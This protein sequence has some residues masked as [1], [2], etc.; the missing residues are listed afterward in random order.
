MKDLE[1]TK[2]ES[3]FLGLTGMGGG[4]ASLMWHS[5]AGVG[6]FYLWGVGSN[7]YGILGQNSLQNQSSPVQIPGDWQTIGDAN[8]TRIGTKPDGTLWVWGRGDY[9][10]LGQNQGPGNHRSSPTQIPG[11]DW[12]ACSAAGYHMMAVKT[13]G[14][15]WMWGINNIGMLGQNSTND[16]YSSPVQ[17]PGTWAITQDSFSAMSNSAQAI[18]QDGTMWMWGGNQQGNLMQNTKG[19]GPG[20]PNSVDGYS[21]PRQVANNPS[22]GWKYAMGGG[23]VAFAID[24]NDNL[25]SCGGPGALGTGNPQGTKYSS[26]TQIPGTWTVFGTN[27]QGTTAWGSEDGDL[28]GK[29]WGFNNYGRM[30][31]NQSPNSPQPDSDFKDSPYNMFHSIPYYAA[32]QID[33]ADLPG[34]NNN[35]YGV[36]TSGRLWAWGT[37]SNGALG[38]NQS[39]VGFPGGNYNVDPTARSA[40]VQIG[41]ETTWHSVRRSNGGCSML[42]NQ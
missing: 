33:F 17:V 20:T 16:G 18:K 25:W 10:A 15:L 22:G 6:P 29:S 12:S 7:G 24:N 1:N 32:G 38:Q 13:N 36:D 42:Q 8:T 37:Q 14:E 39:G 27:P 11:T 28:Q 4:V 9:G 2:K 26:P 34:T 41:T 23:P 19:G 3:P 35:G 31:I 30:G 40:P 5:A 21:S